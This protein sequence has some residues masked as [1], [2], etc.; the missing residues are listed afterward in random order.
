MKRPTVTVFQERLFLLLSGIFIAALVASNLIFQ[1]FFTWSPFGVYTFEISV[2]ILPYPITFLVTDIVSEIYGRRRADQIVVTGF[3]ASLF[4]LVVVLIADAVPQTTWSPVSGEVFHKVFGLFGPA[5]FASMTA[6]LAAQFI[7]IR[8]FHFWKKLTRGRHLWLRNN[9]STVVSQLVDT[10]LVLLLLCATGAIEWSRFPGL[11]ENG[12]LFKVLVALVDT[13]LFY[14][15][16]WLLRRALVLGP[17]E[18]VAV[19]QPL[20]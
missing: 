2:G 11:L 19:E 14:L 10:S 5:V 8:I 17:A 9:G 7:D 16:T 12:F 18:E 15:S 4:I 3:F 6:Y 20:A 13:P 1:K